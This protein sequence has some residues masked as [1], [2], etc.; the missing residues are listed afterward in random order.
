MYRRRIINQLLLIIKY[1]L[2]LRRYIFSIFPAPILRPKYLKTGGVP[3]LS[4]PIWDRPFR[5]DHGGASR[6]LPR[7]LLRDGSTPLPLVYP[8]PGPHGARR[9]PRLL[10]PSAR[11]PRCREP[12]GCALGSRT[13]QP[14][15]PRQRCGGLQALRWG[16]P[17]LPALHLKC[18]ESPT[19]RQPGLLRIHGS[20][21]PSLTSDRT[22]ESSKGMRWPRTAG[23]ERCTGA[24]GAC[25]RT[26]LTH[27]PMAMHMSARCCTWSPR[28]W[29]G[30]TTI[31]G[32]HSS[33][34]D[35]IRKQM[36]PAAPVIAFSKSESLRVEGEGCMPRPATKMA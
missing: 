10:W 19:S 14:G 24:A 33:Q 28:W 1:Q 16:C 8:H 27:F 36:L 22:L 34:H 21:S 13:P 32:S 30:R 11:V 23:N 9:K 5:G 6:F 4:P 20:G 17:L 12:A 25:V 31:L 7:P 35:C 26:W 29:Q 3:A 18:T 2:I 15:W